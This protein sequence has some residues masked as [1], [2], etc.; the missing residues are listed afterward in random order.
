MSVLDKGY[1]TIYLDLIKETYNFDIDM[2]FSISDI[3]TSDFFIK[4]TKNG[5][6]IDLSEYNTYLWILK[7]DNTKEYK[8][9]IQ[10][11]DEKGLFYCN[12]E[13]EFKNVIGDYK[14]QVL[15]KDTDGIEQIATRSCFS[16]RVKDDIINQNY[17]GDHK[18]Q[19]NIIF[20]ESTGDFKISKS[21]YNKETNDLEIR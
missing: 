10:E 8:K 3:E 7:K 21:F 11:K 19:I 9:L 4:I 18:E 13:N 2:C 1:R 16:Y 20:D 5:K 12:L 6:E 14:A 15:I 17:E